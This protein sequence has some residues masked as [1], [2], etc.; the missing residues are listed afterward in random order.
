M[1]WDTNLANFEPQILKE[2]FINFSPKIMDCTQTYQFPSLFFSDKDQ[3]QFADMCSWANTIKRKLV[4]KKN[5]QFV[6]I[7]DH[8]WTTVIYSWDPIISEPKNLKFNGTTCSAA[9]SHIWQRK[10]SF[11]TTRASIKQWGIRM[12]FHSRGSVMSQ[13]SSFLAALAIWQC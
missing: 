9:S 8:S 6:N 12:L 4:K 1:V 10:P 5:E 3:H 2:L 13:N 11:I 7:C